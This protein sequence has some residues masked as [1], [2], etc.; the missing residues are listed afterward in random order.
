[1][2]IFNNKQKAK[3]KT[4]NSPKKAT[5]NTYLILIL[6]FCLGFL[7]YYSTKKI[8]AFLLFAD[9]GLFL[10]V[11]VSLDSA[12]T[13]EKKN[14]AMIQTYADF[15]ER[16]FLYSGLENSYL[17]GFQK[18]VDTSPISLL[19]DTLKDFIDNDRKGNLPLQIK[20]S[21]SELTL[22]RSR[23]ERLKDDF[24]YSYPDSRE[25]YLLFKRVFQEKEGFRIPCFVSTILV[26]LL[27]LGC[28]Y[29]VLILQS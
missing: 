18:A 22:I 25:R 1:M 16:F 27:C 5:S 28:L 6:L 23:K 20:N 17:L 2:N 9:F 12:M 10:F 7:T 19:R 8:Q 14:K 26:F 3:G 11:Y 4:K 13:K 24:E 29:Y 15:Y 21:Q